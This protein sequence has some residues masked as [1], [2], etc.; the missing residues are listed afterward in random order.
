MA[1]LGENS[2]RT[3]VVAG[4]LQNELG[5][6]LIA[7]RTRSHSM[8][9]Y[10]EFPGGKINPGESADDALRRELVE[11]LGI[12]I[13]PLRHLL[14]IEHDYP[15]LSVAID[16]YLVAV[17]EGTPDGR[18]GQQLKWVDKATLHLQNLLPA[19]APLVEILKNV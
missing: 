3:K 10:W 7:D 1:G 9:D 18:E 11:E 17:W 12:E 2:P 6:I 19:D 16:F 15:D 8:Q 13:G 4:I 5:R 14:H